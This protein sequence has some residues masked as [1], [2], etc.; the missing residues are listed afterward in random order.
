MG[1]RVNT[2]SEHDEQ[3]ALVH[4]WSSFSK[5]HNIDEPLLFSIPNGAQLGS[6]SNV[7]ARVMRANT[8]K[9]EGLRPGIPDIMIACPNGDYHG[10]FIEMKRLAGGTVSDEQNDCLNKLWKEGYKTVVC[11]GFSAACAEIKAYF[12]THK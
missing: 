11:C 3:T 12:K 8:L 2:P 4:W 10:L 1:K 6:A 5:H 7:R 9:S